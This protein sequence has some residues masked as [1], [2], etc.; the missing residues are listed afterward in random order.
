MR[1]CSSSQGAGSNGSSA[2]TSGSAFLLVVFIFRNGT[3]RPALEQAVKRCQ[4][5]IVA[6]RLRAS[7]SRVGATLP[8]GLL[9]QAPGRAF[10]GSS[11][12]KLT[13]ASDAKRPGWAD[14][15]GWQRTAPTDGPPG[16]FDRCPTWLQIPLALPWMPAMAP[17]QAGHPPL[18]STCDNSYYHFFHFYGSNRLV[19]K[20]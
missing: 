17:S 4:S 8:L 12:R 15:G 13:G 10:G 9:F 14:G 20:V 1:R 3:L 16:S 7:F 6:R 2:L 11:E 5:Q 18:N 19:V